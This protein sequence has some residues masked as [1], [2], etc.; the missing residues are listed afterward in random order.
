MMKKQ[1]LSNLLVAV[2]IL[3]HNFLFWQEK[4][5]LN[6][7]IFSAFIVGCLWFLHPENRSNKTSYIAMFGAML[8]ATMVVWHN[9]QFSKIMHLL[10]MLILL[11]FMQQRELRFIGY[12]LLLGLWSFLDVPIKFISKLRGAKKTSQKANQALRFLKLG[13]LPLFILNI[14]FAIYYFANPQFAKLVD[15]FEAIFQDIKL[16]H[17]SKEWFV[18][19]LSSFYI[20]GA[21][22]WKSRSKYLLTQQQ[23]HTE[24]LLRQRKEIPPNTNVHH[25]P[26][27][28]KNEYR[29]GFILIAA[30][31]ILLLIV[32]FL[33]LKYVWFDFAG[34]T[35][36]NLSYNV[37]A[38]TY[39]LIPS[40]LLAMAVLLFFFRKNLNFYKENQLLKKLSYLWIIQNAVLCFSVAVR[41]SQYIEVSGLAYKRIGV[42]LFLILVLAGLISL[43]FKIKEKKSSYYLVHRNVW[44]CYCLMI[45]ASCVNWD[46]FITRYNIQTPTKVSIDLNFIIDKVSDK[47]IFLLYEYQDQI[48]EKSNYPDKTQFK[49][50]ISNRL[51]K[52]RQKFEEEQ[53]Q[54]S[55]RSWN[56]ADY[57]NR[58]KLK[59]FN[60]PTMLGSNE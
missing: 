54:Y 36:Q 13:I 43:Y 35:P 28:L 16:I 10:S 48:A 5:G 18:F 17:F 46:T 15:S 38:G 14:F 34:E 57:R 52:K 56:Y 3:L 30:L 53:S 21:I 26:V 23:Q 41:N 32:N 58:Q 2:A 6:S 60:P 37:H 8:T 11:G 44:V 31:N 19:F 47:N 29:M 22:F 59:A 45:L 39:L 25:N 27:S 33:D 9:S 51:N 12:A 55:W 4:M 50:I 7:F 24:S 42:M 20:A 1:I 40:I 49:K